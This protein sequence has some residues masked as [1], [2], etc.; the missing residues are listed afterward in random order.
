MKIHFFFATFAL[1]TTDLSLQGIKRH[2]ITHEHKESESQLLNSNNSELNIEEQM[3]TSGT[4]YNKEKLQ[5]I[6]LIRN[7]YLCSKYNTSI[8]NYPHLCIH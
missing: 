7:I 4:S 5:I 8:S 1:G 6:S 3:A 2:L